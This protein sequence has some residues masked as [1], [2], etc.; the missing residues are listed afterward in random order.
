MELCGKGPQISPGYRQ[1]DGSILP[2]PL[3]PEGF[4]PLGDAAR[5]ADEAEPELGLVFDGRL[6][7]NFK[8]ATGAFVA[9][10]TLRLQALSAIGGAAADA[11][12][13]GE[14]EAGVGLLLFLNRAAVAELPGADAAA[15]QACPVVRAHLAAGLARLNAGAGGMGGRI[16]RALVLDGA[17]DAASGELT[18]KGYLN[19]ALARARRPAEIARLFAAAPDGGVIVL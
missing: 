17:P 12:V 15:P 5:F 18:D 14:G 9:T 1:A 16:F 11:V 8:L 2:A 10:G 19:Q 7:E 6:V 4:L 13:C 3:D